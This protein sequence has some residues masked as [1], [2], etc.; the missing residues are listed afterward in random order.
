MNFYE[1]KYLKYK[2]KYLDLKESMR[3]GEYKEN[4]LPPGHNLGGQMLNSQGDHWLVLKKDEPKLF[5]ES[6]DYYEDDIE[7]YNERKEMSGNQSMPRRFRSGRILNATLDSKKIIIMANELW[8]M[9]KD[10]MIV[11]GKRHTE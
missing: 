5:D 7:G 3:G 10:Y 1:K 2:Q 11:K 8:H 9:G 6:S 4:D